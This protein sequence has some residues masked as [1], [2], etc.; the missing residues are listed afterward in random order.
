M[1]ELVD[2]S[3][4]I[5]QFTIILFF[6][7]AILFF[8][9][10]YWYAASLEKTARSEEK[11]RQALRV[12]SLELDKTQLKNSILEAES[13][14][15]RE[16]NLRLEQEADFRS[17][18]LVSTTLLVGQQRNLFQTVEAMIRD[19][20]T[21]KSISPVDLRKIRRKLSTNINMEE[22]WKSFREQFL[23]VHPDFFK[24]LREEYP[25]LT[26]NDLRHCA[27][28][29]MGLN[30]KEISQLLGINPSSVQI[31]RVRLKKKMNLDRGTDLQD[32][33]RSRQ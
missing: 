11:T 1:V 14:A 20:E 17:N 15:K 5:Y 9:A 32:F 31:S 8:L 7:V 19:V 3:Q 22:G 29:K 23:K 27:Y 12:S 21:K 13:I 28:I 2:N 25:K 18:E 33:V 24:N 4:E 30:T 10:M 26:Q 16:R 6:L